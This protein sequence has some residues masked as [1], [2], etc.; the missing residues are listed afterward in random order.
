MNATTDQDILRWWDVDAGWSPAAEATG[1]IQVIDSWLMDEG[2]VR[3]F[4]RHAQRFGAA[5]D[6]FSGLGMEQTNRFLHA[7]AESLPSRGR[8]FPRVELV[9][10][11]GTTRFRIWVRPAPPR[12]GTVRLWTAAG[13]DHRR[14]PTVKGFDLARLTALRA[15]AVEMGAD[16]ALLVSPEGHVLEGTST[17]ISWWRGDTLCAPPPGPGLLPGVTRA[18]LGELAS[19]AGHP[20]VTESATVS[21]LAKVPV[22]TLNALHGIRPVT[23]GLG[24]FLEADALAAARWQ[25]RLAAVAIPISAASIPLVNT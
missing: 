4:D 7:V 3:G 23:E 8:W 22:W 24:R 5:C 13:P 9:A 12:T 16:E 6:R 18:L 21:D 14:L 11:G 2:R 15:S 25:S 17:S 19:E 1:T 10:T 20:V